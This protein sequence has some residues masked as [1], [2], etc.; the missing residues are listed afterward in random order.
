MSSPI[1]NEAIQQASQIIY[2]SQYA[3]ALTGAGISTPSGIPD[4]RSQG[5]GLWTKNN[6]FRVA[7]LT[8]FKQRPEVFYNWLRPLAESMWQAQPNPAHIALAELEKAGYIKAVIT[9]NIDLLH[10]KAGSRNIIEVHGS[11]NSLSCLRCQTKY[12]LN[13]FI[14]PFLQDK[15]MPYCPSCGN[16]L[17]P[18]IV[19]IEEFLPTNTW[20]QAQFHC[21]EADVMIVI[22]SSLEMYPAAS[23]PNYAVEN[24]AHL[25]INTLSSTPMDNQADILLPYN[26]EETIP[27]IAAEIL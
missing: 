18:D 14:I 21:Q 11:M 13:D 5:T 15:R 1:N 27:R 25:I 2:N 10:Q 12:P 8:A 16:L 22:G 6:P 7:S 24:G 20:M 4:F 26:V 3:I 19:L 17:K 9:Q 23:L